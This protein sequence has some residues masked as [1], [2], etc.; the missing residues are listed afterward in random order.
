MDLV[1][2]HLAITY[3]L[4]GARTLVVDANWEEP[5]L[6]ARFG[7]PL[8]ERG[9]F[10][11]LVDVGQNLRA[12]LDAI[13][14]TP[15]PDLY[16]LPVGPI[17]P[18]IDDLL[19]S[20]LPDQLLAAL[21]ASFQQIVV[22]APAELHTD[23]AQQL[24]GRMH[25]ALVVAHTGSTTGQQ[26]ADTAQSLRRAHCYLA[27]AVLVSEHGMRPPGRVNTAGNVSRPQVPSGSFPPTVAA[28]SMTTP[29]A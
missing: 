27:G 24:I 1:G 6:E 7:L 14:S 21:T 23:A 29:G 9:F 22:L 16:A 11:S 8:A 12:P 4:A 26:L 18:N 5:T 25:G 2:S 20:S 19:L 17:P 28:G 10:T 3:A 13:V 15:I